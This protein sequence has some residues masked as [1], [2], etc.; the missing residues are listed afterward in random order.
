MSIPIIIGNWKLNSNKNFIKNFIK[1][2]DI[3]IKNYYRFCKII[4]TPPII[5]L[6]YMQK[7]LLKKNIYLGAQNVDFNNLGAFTGEI[8]PIMLK[9][10]NISYVIIGHSERRINHYENNESI[11]KKFLVLK[12]E[13]LIP[14]LCIGETKNEKT[15]NKTIDVCKKQ[16]DIIF[17]Y[18]GNNAFNNTIIAYEPIWAIGSGISP[19]LQEIQSLASFL[20]DYIKYKS[21]EKLE[22]F[23]IQYGGSVTSKNAKNIISLPDINGLLIGNSSLILEEFIKIIKIIN[24]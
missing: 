11:A 24:C 3:E 5:Y 10:F 20:K 1:K 2:F 21:K 22:N 4:I 16:I 8:S 9:D 18:C 12:K 6:Y 23:Y 13:N 7:L 17:K 14:I 15:E 19:S